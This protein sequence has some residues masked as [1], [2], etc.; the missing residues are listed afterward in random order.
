MQLKSSD[1]EENQHPFQVASDQAQIHH[2]DLTYG[3]EHVD[4]NDEIKTGTD[5]QHDRCFSVVFSAS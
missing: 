5:E 3:I 4:E 1:E 2:I